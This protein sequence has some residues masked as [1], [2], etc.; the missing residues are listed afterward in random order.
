MNRQQEYL[1]IKVAIRA[2]AH[3]NNHDRTTRALTPV[4]QYILNISY[5]E[6]S[7]L[8]LKA[9]IALKIPEAFGLRDIN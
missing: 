1:L 7:V 6:G 3:K 5:V 8:Q 9:E 4:N 2:T